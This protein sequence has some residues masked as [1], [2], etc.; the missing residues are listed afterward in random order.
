M[1][2]ITLTNKATNAGINPDTMRDIDDP[3]FVWPTVA[4]VHA[5][6]QASGWPRGKIC[7]RLGAQPKAVTK[8]LATGHTSNLPIPY[9][10]WLL[11][12]VD[13][14]LVEVKGE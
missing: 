8:W 6:K 1:L 10:A 4:D 9:S 11:W 5:L 12:L 14:G 7:A 3:L 13:A 2:K